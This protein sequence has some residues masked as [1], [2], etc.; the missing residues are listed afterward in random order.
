[1]SQT[2]DERLIVLVE[3]RIKDLERN[4]AKASATTGREFGK[5]RRD[6]QSATA[7]MERDMLR[8]T[9]RINQAVAATSSR[10][11]T[12]SKSFIA[13]GQSSG[14]IF[15]SA[16][17]LRGAQ[18]FIDNS[19]KITNALKAAG[20]EGKALTGVYDALFAS[21]Q[22]NAAPLES[23]IKLYSA[24]SLNM[25]ELNTNSSEL[26]GFTD[27]IAMA[28]RAGG[29]SASEASGALMQLSQALGGG[30]VRAE[31]FNSIVEGAPVIA[32][33]AAAGIREAGG[34]VAMLRSLMLDGKI[35]S[36]AFFRGIEAGS[37]MIA[38][39]LESAQRTIS[40]SF[41]TLFNSL[42]QAAGEFNNSSEAA[43][44]FGKAIDNLAAF[45]N[46]V[47]FDSLIGQVQ[48]YIN[49]INTALGTTNDFI[50]NLS[51]ISGLRNIGDYLVST[52]VG[53]AIGLQAPVTQQD[54]LRTG[55]YTSDPALDAYIK[56]R[57]PNGNKTGRIE[58]PQ[59]ASFNPIS[60]EDYKPKAV[61]KGRGQTGRSG[62]SGGSR[63]ASAAKAE[64]EADAVRDLIS[65]LDREKSLI[66]ATDV[67]R[68]ISNALRQAGASATDEQ[69]GRIT[70]LVTAID[71]E[72]KA[73]DSLKDAQEA[74]KGVA[75]DALH[76]IA[77][78]IRAG[79]DAGDILNDV[80][81]NIASKLI[82]MAINNLVANAFDGGG[83]GFGKAG[84][85]GGIFGLL[86]SVLG[87][88]RGGPVQAAR[89]GAIR[90]PGTGTSDSIPAMLSDGEFVVNAKAAR[91]H[92]SLLEELNL[93]GLPGYASGGDV[94][95]PENPMLTRPTFDLGKGKGQPAVQKPQKVKITVDVTGA[96][97]DKQIQDMVMKGVRAGIGQYDKQLN[98]T[99][100]KKLAINQARG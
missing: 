38:E 16:L 52:S 35:S 74:L 15:A 78:G 82:D 1:M 98:L 55:G 34:S 79:A 40:D 46:D 77:N 32:Q 68:E 63:D 58:S 37:P 30:V 67:E 44:T 53:Q 60:V 49:A 75:S 81:D 2:G 12:F 89:G 72:T 10:L 23:L 65:D 100:G 86:G 93:G 64:R 41:T 43:N 36:E 51:R 8:S 27:T 56:K 21:A 87:F 28:L 62:G 61:P 85:G 24:V 31:E 97:G 59:P 19:I 26:V 94:R 3:A 22:R 33:A 11:G 88:S 29:T 91:R 70:E 69:K 39:R 47:N 80:L 9:S 73:M 17:A 5:M 14:G 45:I 54:R 48:G 20:L 92:R 50:L 13:F 84:G 76:T 83:G 90:G 4:M 96:N 66:G 99:I 18:S 71:T 57:Y 6:S 95:R 25:S 7:A 42:T